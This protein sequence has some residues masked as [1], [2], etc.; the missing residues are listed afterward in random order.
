MVTR[1]LLWNALFLLLL[2]STAFVVARQ[3]KRLD[4]VDTAW[5]LAYIVPASL[6]LGFQLQAS[7]IVIGIAVYIWAIRLA[8]HILERNRHRSDDPRYQELSKKWGGNFWL[9]AYVSIFFTQAVLVWLVSIPV[10]MATNTPLRHGTVLVVLGALVWVSGFL[11]EA[12][13][14]RQLRIF[15]QDKRHHGHTLQTGLWRYSRH[16]N[17]FGELT[18]W[19]G[20]ALIAASVRFGWVGFIGPVLLTIL[21]VFVSGLPPIERRRQRDAEYQTYKRRTSALIPWLPKQNT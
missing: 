5:G 21:I 20:I 14:D 12:V 6:A 2:M 10:V 9:R 4:T 19:Y 1:V 18:Q 7:T 15:L 16:P 17:Y 13:A 8:T 3:R 11:V